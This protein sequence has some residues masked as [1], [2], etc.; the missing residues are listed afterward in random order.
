[1]HSMREAAISESIVACVDFILRH[2]SSEGSWADWALPPGQ[3]NCWV[4]AYVGCRL[5]DLPRHLRSRTAPQR[6]NAARWLAQQESD[7]GGWG[8]NHSVECDAD[9]TAHT[10]LFLSREGCP[11]PERNYRFL[12]KF[13]QPDGGFSTYPR[14]GGLGSWGMSH[15]DVSAVAASAL[16]TYPGP[17]SAQLRRAVRYVSEQRDVNGMWNSFWWSSALYATEVSLALLRTSHTDVDFEQT[18]R[19]LFSMAATNAFE[20]ALLIGCLLHAVDDATYERVHALVDRLV[21]EQLPDGSWASVPILRLT[22]R[23]CTAPWE[24]T[25]AGPMY[26]DPKRLFTSATALRALC[27][28]IERPNRS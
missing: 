14:D 4:T 11:A 22:D 17:G 25:Q 10:I 23:D 18:R 2:Q 9:S 15:P 21:A 16:L 6:R 19:T 24:C 8:Y 5:A 28:A 13:Q 3:S 7:C 27:S 26:A 1:M 20:S 12:S